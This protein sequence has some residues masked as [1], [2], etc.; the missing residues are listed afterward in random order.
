LNIADLVKNSGEKIK[1]IS[2]L[3]YSVGSRIFVELSQQKA[4]ISLMILMFQREV[5]KRITAKTGEDYG[6]LSVIGGVA[7]DSKIL[8]DV[9]PANFKPA[10]AVTSSVIACTPNAREIA[11]QEFEKFI[12]ISRRLFENRRKMIRSYAG[13]LVENFPEYSEKRAENLTVDDLLKLTGLVIGK[14][15]EG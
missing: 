8:F 9:S 15:L 14:D 11:G 12:R 4:Q 6:L 3:P 10:P 7:F 13:D 2:N 5:A 1:V